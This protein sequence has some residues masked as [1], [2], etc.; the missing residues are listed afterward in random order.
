MSGGLRR[1]AATAAVPAFVLGAAALAHANPMSVAVSNPPVV[2]ILLRGGTLAIRTWDRP[3]VQV[4]SSDQFSTSHFNPNVVAKSVPVQIN[5]P[6]GT[7]D[8]ADGPVTLPVESFPLSSVSNSPHDGVV[9]K[10]A[11][12]N[13]TTVMIPQNTALLIVQIGRGRVQLSGYRE[14]TFFIHTRAAGV[15]LNNDGGNGYVQSMRGPIVATDSKFSRLRARTALGNMRFERCHVTQIQANSI[16][17]SIVYDNGSF[18]PGLARFESENG[19]VAL[20]LAAGNN[21]QFGAHSQSG[22]IY[23]TFDRR[24]DVSGNSTDKTATLGSGGPVVTASSHGGAVY[25]Y[26][27]TLGQHRNLGPNWQP[28]RRVKSRPAQSARAP[29]KQRNRRRR[30]PPL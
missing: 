14:G 7:I 11:F 23:S 12:A 29:V 22:R 25:L 2:R 17:G 1:L 15:F 24:A 19:N 9:L 28:A 5:V 13:S 26:D 30:P 4:D 20:G 18:E 3:A 10:A 8:G 16:D 21:V 27:G 6:S